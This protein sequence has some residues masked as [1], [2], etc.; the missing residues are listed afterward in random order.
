MW[1]KFTVFCLLFLALFCNGKVEGERELHDNHY[2]KCIYASS[3][4]QKIDKISKYFNIK[5]DEI[6]KQGID[7][8]FLMSSNTVEFSFYNLS[9]NI[10]LPLVRIED[11]VFLVPEKKVYFGVKL[12]EKGE[13]SVWLEKNKAN[14]FKEYEMIGSVDN[15]KT[16]TDC[17]D[18]AKI[19]QI[20]EER[21]RE[22][23]AGP[24]PDNSY[25]KIGS[26]GFYTLIADSVL[27]R[28]EPSRTSK[29]LSKL[30]KGTTVALLAESGVIEEVEPYGKHSWIKIRLE[31]G[32]IGYV[33]GAFVE[34]KE[35]FPSGYKYE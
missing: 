1:N 25:H 34:W 35:P 29:V 24:A 6:E 27:L 26:L 12:Y 33:F 16:S 8:Y 20:Y 14:L 32:K 22:I 30:K 17:L 3:N 4:Y 19:N 23:E 28:E 13:A 7:F 18:R 10:T 11:N 31:N 2:E 5:F 21:K 9:N 15:R